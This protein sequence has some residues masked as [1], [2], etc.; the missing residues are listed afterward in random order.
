MAEVVDPGLHA[1]VQD[2]DEIVARLDRLPITS[3]HRLSCGIIALGSFFDAFDALLLASAIAVVISVLHISFLYIGLLISAANF[4]MMVGAPFGGLLAEKFGRRPI[5]ILSI[6]SFGLLSIVS[7]FAWDFQSL[8]IIRF[9]EGLA[10]GA[11]IP[12]AAA[13]FNEFVPGRRRARAFLF[14]FGTLFAAGFLFA[15]L[16]GLGCVALF[17]AAIGWRVLFACGGLAVF[18]AVGMFFALPESPRWLASKGRTD[19]ARVILERFE[20]AAR[21]EGKPLPVPAV[22]AQVQAR[23]TRLAEMFSPAYRSRTILIWILF[24]VIYFVAY[25]IASWLPT[26]YVRVGGLP[27]SAA[28]SLTVF[29][30]LTQVAV[31]FFWGSIADRLGRRRLYIITLS[32]I[33]LTMLAGFF[34]VARLGLTGWPVLAVVAFIAG[35]GNGGTSAMSFLYASEL[36]P[37]RMRAWAASTCASANRIG[38]VLAPGAIGA[39]LAAD[40]GLGSVFLMVSCV[41]AIGLISVVVLA[42]ETGSG[43]LEDASA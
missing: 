17:G 20:A 27:T 22:R 43:T 42:P 9:V 29:Y 14:G 40:L 16:I 5:L 35:I 26:L 8:L 18:V 7:A 25:G 24:F 28:L 23:P 13:L 30:G 3:L 38:T 36:F 39:L 12:I 32:L 34:V 10:L 37:T 4:G 6:G 19:E 21:A 41:A 11:E 33:A 31:V 1:G 15:P 2:A